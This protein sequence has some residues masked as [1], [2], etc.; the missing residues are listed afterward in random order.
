VSDFD[1]AGLPC[2]RFESWRLH[3][4]SAQVA[5]NGVHREVRFL[6]I[7]LHSTRRILPAAYRRSTS[8]NR[9]A[10]YWPVV[11]CLPDLQVPDY[12]C[13]KLRTIPDRSSRVYESPAAGFVCSLRSSDHPEAGQCTVMATITR[14][15]R[16]L[17]GFHS[18]QPQCAATKLTRV[19]RGSATGR[20]V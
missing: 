6:Q 11:L 19:R 2:G 20:V 7:L 4:S 12:S 14:I 9:A 18:N 13:R 10:N 1:L 5:L 16:R 15:N 8:P 3:V 17:G